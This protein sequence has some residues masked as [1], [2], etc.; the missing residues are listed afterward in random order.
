M[1][2]KYIDYGI[3]CNVLIIRFFIDKR[4][5]YYELNRGKFYFFVFVFLFFL[6]VLVRIE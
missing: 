6:L 5:F 2:V 1:Y 3:F 4:N